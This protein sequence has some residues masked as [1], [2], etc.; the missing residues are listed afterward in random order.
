MFIK[1]LNVN[2]KFMKERFSSFERKEMFLMT[3]KIFLFVLFV[4]A[5]V[6]TSGIAFGYKFDLKTQLF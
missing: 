6:V 1:L 4:C 3:F 5:I 2:N